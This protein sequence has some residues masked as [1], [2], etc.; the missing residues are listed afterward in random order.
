MGR[1]RPVALRLNARDGMIQGFIRDCHVMRVGMQQHIRPG[2]PCDMAFP[3]QKIIPGKWR[4]QNLAP[5]L[6]CLLIAIARTLQSTGKGSSLYQ[7]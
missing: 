4:N 6:P 1:H 3:K 7:A 2:N 5:E